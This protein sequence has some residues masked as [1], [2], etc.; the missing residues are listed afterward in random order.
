[1]QGIGL[2]PQRVYP[3]PVLA[4]YLLEELLLQ[5]LCTAWVT[6]SLILRGAGWDIT[7]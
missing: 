4:D 7:I 2:A 1:M 5:R 6:Q 3:K